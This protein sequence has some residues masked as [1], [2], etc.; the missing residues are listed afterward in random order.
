MTG[1]DFQSLF[2]HLTSAPT[3]NSIAK[4]F[5]KAPAPCKLKLF[6][7]T[8]IRQKM[9]PNDCSRSTVL[10]GPSL[11]ICVLCFRRGETHAHFFLHCDIVWKLWACIFNLSSCYWVSPNG[12]KF[13]ILSINERGVRKKALPLWQG[14]LFAGLWCIWFAPNSTI[15]NSRHT[16]YTELWERVIFLAIL[17]TK[18]RG[19]FCDI[20]IS[21]LHRSWD[22][23]I[24]SM[25]PCCLF[26]F[27]SPFLS[28]RVWV[29]FAS[30]G[31]CLICCN[32]LSLS[33][34]Q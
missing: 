16:S 6:A 4:V 15:F 24:K 10:I 20:S 12:G 11:W 14:V 5:W 27:L 28:L 2:Q 7:W 19:H 21:I 22:L 1:D 33:L 8:T 29:F 30:F 31:G 34:S 25:Q 3:N 9:N 26:V 13:L 17:W 32:S 23:F 18:E